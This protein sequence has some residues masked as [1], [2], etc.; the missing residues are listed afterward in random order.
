MAFLRNIGLRD[1]VLHI[2]VL[3]SGGARNFHLGV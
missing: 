3:S 1:V 2:L